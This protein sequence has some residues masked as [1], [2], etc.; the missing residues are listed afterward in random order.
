[1]SATRRFLR[2]GRLN[3]SVKTSITSATSLNGNALVEI[4]AL[5]A[6]LAID[7]MPGEQ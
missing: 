3:C 6:D 1:M 7:P 2:S 4:K 5:Q